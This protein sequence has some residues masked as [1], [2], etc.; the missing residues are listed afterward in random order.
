MGMHW[1][2]RRYQNKDGTL[3]EVGKARF[4]KSAENKRVNR[5]DTRVGKSVARYNAR[6]NRKAATK[7][8]R[9]RHGYAE[10]A[11]FWERYEQSK[12]TL[13]K[14]KS[15]E[16]KAGRDFITQT[17]VNYWLILP[18]ANVQKQIIMNPDTVK[19]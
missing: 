10:A 15:G 11:L 8:D 4:L 18:I 12:T 13:S 17:D 5:R 3:T 16:L 9:K 7:Y 19:K 6:I 2:V 14:I 1:G